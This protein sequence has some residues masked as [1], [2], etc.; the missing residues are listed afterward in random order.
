MVLF[1]A[2]V[3]GLAAAGSGVL[4]A[5]FGLA[6]ALN[7]SLVLFWHQRDTDMSHLRP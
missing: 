6:V 1:A 4:A 7:L 3:A 5:L 2:A